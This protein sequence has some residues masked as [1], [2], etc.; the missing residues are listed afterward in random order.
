MHIIAGFQSNKYLEMAIQEI[1]EFGINH[2]RIVVVEMENQEHNAQV[3][4]TIYYS[5]GYSLLD[6]MAPWS[7]V[8]ALLGVIWG[9]KF[10]I[11]PIATGLI[12][13][14]VGASLGYYFDKFI[15][16]KKTNK[17]YKNYIDFLLIVKCRSEQRKPAT[18]IL[19]QHHAAAI[20][21][22]GG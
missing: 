20:G 6:G 10:F 3:F 19:K 2:E 12:G 7:V 18:S 14:V 15:K 11:G 8:G 5:D 4:D 21:Y 1:E 16:H 9:S 13:F 22:H 17:K